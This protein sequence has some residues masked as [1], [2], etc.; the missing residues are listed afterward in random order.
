MS[1][2]VNIKTQFK[3]IRNLV[4]QFESLGWVVSHNTKCVTYPTDPR[5]DELHAYV[6]KNPRAN[7]YDVGIDIDEEGN[8][9]FVCD[10]F[11]S[12][13][14]QQLGK[15]LQKIKQGYTLS[16]IERQL[17]E[18]NFEYSVEE[19]ATGETVVTAYK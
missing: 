15:N 8:A 4:E 7:G 18:D 5:R 19:L 10:F 13:I 11:D 2:S 17:Q 6:A 14:E 3:N 12:S 1:H 16:E 9:Y